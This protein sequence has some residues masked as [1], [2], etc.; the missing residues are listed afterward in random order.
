MYIYKEML[1]GQN[2]AKLNQGL[3]IYLR[4]NNQLDKWPMFKNDR[5]YLE[6]KKN[7][8]KLNI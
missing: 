2:V 5:F 3:R 4:K 1:L 7:R 8:S 6:M